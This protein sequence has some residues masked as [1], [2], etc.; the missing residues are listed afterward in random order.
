MSSTELPSEHL[1]FNRKERYFTGTVLPGI[2]AGDRLEHLDRFLDLC[3]LPQVLDQT[4]AAPKVQFL[5][6]YGF[7]ESAPFDSSGIWDDCIDGRDTPDVVIAGPDWILSVEAKLYSTPT[8]AELEAQLGRQQEL[9]DCWAQTLELTSDR[10][11]L[12]AL[13]AEGHRAEMGPLKW[14]STDG[15]VGWVRVRMPPGP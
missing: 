9:L 7:A 15:A 10:V 14:G 11:R 8:A 3:G 12:V 4:A 13:V 6:E 1:P 5:T 2:V